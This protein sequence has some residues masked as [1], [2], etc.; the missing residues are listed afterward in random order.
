[1]E[2][3][4]YSRLPQQ[5]HPDKS[6]EA[7]QKRALDAEHGRSSGKSSALEDN[8]A[9]L[10]GARRLGSNQAPF[11]VN[12][13]NNMT[14]AGTPESVPGPLRNVTTSARRTSNSA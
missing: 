14:F 2:K 1:M 7:Q 5:R 12:P 9:L 8:Q 6:F 3:C 10:S 11:E 4:V 13:V